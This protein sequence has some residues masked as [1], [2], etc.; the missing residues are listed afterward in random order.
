M[1]NLQDFCKLLIKVIEVEK[2]NTFNQREW[3]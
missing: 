2:S 1:L 3:N